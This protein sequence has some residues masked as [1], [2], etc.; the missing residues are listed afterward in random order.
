[1]A[2]SRVRQVFDRLTEGEKAKLYGVLFP[3][4]SHASKSSHTYLVMENVTTYFR[5]PW[6]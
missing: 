4:I 6:D 5:H 2:A 1:M 3:N